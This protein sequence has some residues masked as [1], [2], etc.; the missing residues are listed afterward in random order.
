VGRL[1][2]SI[3]IALFGGSP[4]VIEESLAERTSLLG[5]ALTAELPNLRLTLSNRPENVSLVR[6]VLAGLAEAVELDQRA[7]EDIKAAV[8]EACNNVVLHAYRGREG[9]LEIELYNDASAIVV[10]VRDAGVGIGTRVQ[11]G[12]E[13]GLGI[14]LRMIRALVDSVEF[15]AAGAAPGREGSAGTEVRMKFGVAGARPLEV[16]QGDG[17][18]EPS[19]TAASELGSTLTMTLA[20]ARLAATVLPRLLSLVAVRAQ[21]SSASVS[22]AQRVASALARYVEQSGNGDQV[23]VGIRTRP[24]GLELRVAPVPTDAAKDL[25]ADAGVD[26]QAPVVAS[27]AGGEAGNHQTLVLR[28]VDRSLS[29]S[30][31]A[32]L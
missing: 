9:P 7:L 26:G 31:P 1:D 16:V 10:V 8:T 29:T 11:S 18:F 12:E 28:L 24:H 13:S 20:P 27:L 15:Q 32:G 21:L 23:S 22:D 3:L 4:P 5:H 30:E 25:V 14:G 17:S 2:W 6:E 19:A